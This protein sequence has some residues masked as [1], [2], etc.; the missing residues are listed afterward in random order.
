LTFTR[1]PDHHEVLS[2]VTL[3]LL[4]N[5][6]ERVIYLLGVLENCIA[7]EIVRTIRALGCS[8]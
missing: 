7:Q 8:L 4:G 2:L 6:L 3:D 1:V 5:I